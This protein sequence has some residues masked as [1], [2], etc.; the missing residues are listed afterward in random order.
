MFPTKWLQIPS[1][2]S[3]AAV[4]RWE[5]IRH[6][7]AIWGEVARAVGL[8][9]LAGI[10]L[11]VEPLV[12]RDYVRVLLPGLTAALLLHPV[13]SAGKLFTRESLF[14]RRW[15]TLPVPLPWFGL[16]GFFP[17]L[18]LNLLG[19]VVFLGIF[20][21]SGYGVVYMMHPL[22]WVGWFLLVP[23]AL[24]WGLIVTSL[25]LLTGQ[26]TSLRWGTRRLFEWVGAVFVPASALPVFVLPFHYLVPHGYL[27]ELGRTLG[28]GTNRSVLKALVGGAGIG[29]LVL[30]A[31]GC[32]FAYVLHRYVQ[33]GRFD[34]PA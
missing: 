18:A 12:G 2:R 33:T 10:L 30:V 3:V 11:A 15:R 22:F 23:G 4:F 31:G 7:H 26:G 32:C 5:M 17:R 9:A 25:A 19:T 21:W 29:L 28:G 34:H 1:W 20:R 13:L 27:A 8:V 6:V 14:P 24:G 16:A